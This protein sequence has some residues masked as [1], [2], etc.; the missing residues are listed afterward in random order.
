MSRTTSPSEPG[1]TH[2]VALHC[3]PIH[4]E[5][6]F[7]QDIGSTNTLQTLFS[8]GSTPT[9]AYSAGLVSPSMLQNP[10]LRQ[11]CISLERFLHVKIDLQRY[12]H[13]DYLHV[14]TPQKADFHGIIFEVSGDISEMVVTR[15]YSFRKCVPKENNHTGTYK[16]CSVFISIKHWKAHSSKLCVFR[17]FLLHWFLCDCVYHNIPALCCSRGCV[18]MCNS[19]QSCTVCAPHPH[20]PS[21]DAVILKTSLSLASHFSERITPINNQCYLYCFLT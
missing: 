14:N 2:K 12:L 11:R 8:Q 4:W 6:F 3:S 18:C 10:P 21:R 7:R 5:W 17:G 9:Q 16:R 20:H 19:G 1:V 13:C 15:A